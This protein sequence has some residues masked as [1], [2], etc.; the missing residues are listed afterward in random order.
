MHDFTRDKFMQ[1]LAS[2]KGYKDLVIRHDVD[3]S[4]HDALMLAQA[5]AAAGTKSIY[6][7]RSM[8]FTSERH[9]PDIRAVAALGHRVGY[10]YESLTTCRGNVDA[11]YNDFCSNLELLR[12]V[13]PVTTA[14]AH[15]SPRSPWDSQTIWNQYDIH[16]LGI[17]YEPMLDTN[18]GRTLYLT[19][20]GRR[21]DGYRLSVRDKVPAS[22]ARWEKEG[23]VFHRTDDI[24]HAIS[25]VDHPIHRY[26]LL[27][28]AHPERWTDFGAQWV[29]RA[30]VRWWKNQAKR[31]Y[32]ALKA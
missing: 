25:T 30:G 24:I 22:Q 7:F 21:W 26:A 19:D 6:Y 12:R 10:H 20:T 1:L 23:L 4:T 13:A 9:L 11:A 3:L 16:A 15:G 28:N 2:L 17:D 14:C 32:V 8:H 29:V 31:L 5:E 27:L 18:F